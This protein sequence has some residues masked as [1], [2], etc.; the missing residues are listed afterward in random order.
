MIKN[1]AVVED[2]TGA[3]LNTIIAEVAFEVAPGTTKLEQIPVY[4]QGT[5]SVTNGSPSVTVSGALLQTAGIK[6]GQRVFIIDS[7][8]VDVTMY[9]IVAI[10]SETSFTLDVNYAGST[11][12]TSV[13]FINPISKGDVI[14]I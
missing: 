7:G 8:D 2:A 12:G 4:S 9:K 5:A 1:Y 6:V 13:Y 14:T 11:N 3:V 10:N